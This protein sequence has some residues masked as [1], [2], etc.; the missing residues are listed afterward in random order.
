LNEP[1]KKYSIIRVD[2]NRSSFDRF[3][4]FESKADSDQAGIFTAVQSVEKFGH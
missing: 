1:R 2:V 4:T 3:K